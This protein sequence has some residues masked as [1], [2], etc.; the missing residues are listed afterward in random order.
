[1]H[2]VY[3]CS[4][5]CDRILVTVTCQHVLEELDTYD[6]KLLN[7]STSA[8]ALRLGRGV[9]SAATLAENDMGRHCYKIF[10]NEL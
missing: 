3:A 7:G 2:L 1:M 6:C 4:N 8:D 9:T 10:D 5:G